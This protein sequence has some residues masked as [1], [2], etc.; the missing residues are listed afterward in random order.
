MTT[1]TA[2]QIQAPPQVHVSEDS[3][4]GAASRPVDWHQIDWS[5]AHRIVRRLQARIVKATQQGRWGKV[6]A[7]QHLLTHSHS[8]KV[9]AV[10]RVTENHGKRTAGVDRVTW[11]TPEQKMAAVHDLRQRGYRPQPLRRVYI[12]K[13]NGKLR[14]LSIPTMKDRAMQA[15]YLLA[16]DPVAETTADPNSYG[17]RRE[18]STADA[19]EQ[20]FNVLA[21][22]DKARWILEGDIRSCFDRIS[23]DWLLAHIPLEKAILR[24]WLKAGFLDKHVLHPTEDG[25]PQGG[26]A[27]PVLANLT[28]DGLEGRLRAAFPR[29][30]TRYRGAKVNLIRYADDFVITGSSHTLLEDEVKPLV[31]QFLVERGLELSL[32][33]TQITRIEDGFDFLGQTVRKYRRGK[34][35]KLLITPSQKNVKAFLDKVRV[36][37]RDSKQAPAGELILQL[38]PLIR[39]WARYHRHAV[40]RKTFTRVTHA[41]FVLLWRWARRRHPN[42]GKGWVKKRYFRTTPTREWIFAARLTGPDGAARQVRLAEAV[43]MP[44]QR[45]IKIQAAANPYDPAWEVYFEQ[46][47]GVK[48]EHTLQGRRQLLTLWK[49]Q[50]GIC[51]ICTRKITTLSGWHN[52]HLVWRSQGG[53]DGAANRVLLHPTCHYQVHSQRLSVAKPRPATGVGK[54]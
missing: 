37:V 54:A 47:L 43:D 25:T 9:L 52:H 44:I 49:E 38:N 22:S 48:M 45:H 1:S 51:P 46:R 19:I 10:R 23:H 33:K 6:Q 26:I 27:S 36:I 24:K 40:S 2:A 28:L 13:R 5:H 17:F 14:P 32:E 21:R 50:R 4:C 16:L 53:A 7:L 41:I 39:G 35:E 18:R 11:D 29:T 20:C 8:G 12:P 31:E 34:Q 15:L 30:T 42:K 3:A